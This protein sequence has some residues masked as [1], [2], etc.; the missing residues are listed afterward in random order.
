MTDAQ[1]GR[2]RRGGHILAWSLVIYSRLLL[3]AAPALLMSHTSP[4]CSTALWCSATIPP[5]LV[6]IRTLK[7]QL[8]CFGDNEWD[9]NQFP[10][11]EFEYFC[12]ASKLKQLSV[13]GWWQ[14]EGGMARVWPRVD[15]FQDSR[16]GLVLACSQRVSSREAVS[17]N[18]FTSVLQMFLTRSTWH[19]PNHP[20]HSGST[21]SPL[22]RPWLSY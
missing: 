8:E 13:G 10:S 5:D 22:H 3:A 18:C 20:P 16:D 2:G 11:R 12:K 9:L 17:R 15:V 14:V 4:R 19:N 1:S 7:L 21:A 6:K